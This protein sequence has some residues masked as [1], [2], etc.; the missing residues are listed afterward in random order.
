MS[1]AQEFPTQ[2]ILTAIAIA[3]AVFLKSNLSGILATWPFFTC[4][5]DFIK[6]NL[7]K[8]DG[9]KFTFNVLHVCIRYTFSMC[10]VHPSYLYGSV[11]STPS[12]QLRA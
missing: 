1:W 4:R 3:F 5:Y 11:R 6:S 7:E 9:H 12:W 2:G 8:I 10:D